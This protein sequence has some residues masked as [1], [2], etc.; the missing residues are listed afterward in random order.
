MVCVVCFVF[1]NSEKSVFA[2]IARSSRVHPSNNPTNMATTGS[3]SSPVLQLLFSMVLV[4]IAFNVLVGVVHVDALAK[5][6]KW[7]GASHVVDPVACSN[8]DEWC[9]W[10][11]TDDNQNHYDLAG[12]HG[13]C[14]K[15]VSNNCDHKHYTTF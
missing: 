6:Y 2:I 11:Q 8:G 13:N 5:C 12:F 15:E 10:F 3:S 14:Y 1:S 4:L 7:Q 9:Y